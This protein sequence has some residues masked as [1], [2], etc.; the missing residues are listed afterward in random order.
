MHLS[1]EGL[2]LIKSFEGY[3]TALPDGGCSAY[4][5]PAKVPTIGWGCTEGVKLG[6]VWT[7]QQ[8]EAALQKEVSKFEEGVARLVT[9]EINQNQ[10]DAL[11]SF[12]YNV[13]LGALQRSSVLKAVNTGNFAKVPAALAQWNKGGGK[14]LPGLVSRRQREGSLFMKPMAAPEAPFMPQKVTK[15]LSWW[16]LL[17]F[18]LGLGGGALTGG[19]AATDNLPFMP[20]PPDT[21]AATAWTAYGDTVLA[22]GKWALAHPIMTL[23]VLGTIAVLAFPKLIPERWRPA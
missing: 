2:R 16:Q 1:D 19:A 3:H 13:G 7:K 18:R 14:V 23:V 5:C 17:M 11:V 15:S 8:A 20:Q 6:M 12:A 4:L 21:S 9:A 10:F 22:L